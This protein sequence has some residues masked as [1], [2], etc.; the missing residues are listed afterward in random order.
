MSIKE[1][2][3]KEKNFLYIRKYQSKKIDR[4]RWMCAM[5]MLRL[6]NEKPKNEIAEQRRLY[7]YR[8]FYKIWRL[9]REMQI[10]NEQTLAKRGKNGK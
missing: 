4:I 6:D 9:C 10:E 1:D 7:E 3:L 2:L 5:T 8:F